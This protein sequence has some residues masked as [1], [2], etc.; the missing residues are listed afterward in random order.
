MT[1]IGELACAAKPT[2]PQHKS[3]AKSAMVEL[4]E[5]LD[6]LQKRCSP[7]VPWA[8]ADGSC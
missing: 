1:H 4:A 2:G 7:K 3:D 6:A 8:T 5:R